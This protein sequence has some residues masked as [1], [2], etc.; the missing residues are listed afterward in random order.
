[1]ILGD[2]NRRIDRFV[3]DD[4]LW[5]EIDDNDPPGLNLWRL[6]F[7]REAECH[8]SFPQPIDFLEFADRAWQMVDQG[9]LV[10]VT[11]DPE[12]QDLGRRTVSDHCPIAVSLELGAAGDA[13][14]N[15]PPDTDP[16]DL[17]LIYAPAEGLEGRRAAGRAPRDRQPR[18]Q[19]PKLREVW[20]ALDFTNEDPDNPDNVILLYTGRSHP[21][22]R[23]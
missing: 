3:Q 22:N 14:D 11:Y 17:N 15:G 20:G 8:P 1:M 21:S 19:P 10:E 5:R 4:H 2:F 18:S 23:P 6:P 13:D 9:S 7:G 16:T 12:D